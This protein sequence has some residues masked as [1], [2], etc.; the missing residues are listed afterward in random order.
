MLSSKS[1]SPQIVSSHTERPEHNMRQP[2][3]VSGSRPSSCAK[4]ARCVWRQTREMISQHLALPKREDSKYHK[5]LF[6]ELVT[7]PNESDRCL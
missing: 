4:A 3:P 2:A 7:L 5:S 1:S 6:V